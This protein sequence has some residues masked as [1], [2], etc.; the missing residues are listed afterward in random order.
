MGMTE[1]WRE[2]SVHIT[3]GIEFEYKIQGKSK[4]MMKN[5][6]I[7]RT[8]YRLSSHEILDTCS[9]F[10]ILTVLISPNSFET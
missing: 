8:E 5:Q 9:L 10:Q 1:F 3:N 6:E 2:F 7:S 4:S